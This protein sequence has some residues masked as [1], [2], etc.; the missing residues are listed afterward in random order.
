M[1]WTDESIRK[2]LSDRRILVVEDDID[3][4]PR[5]ERWLKEW[6]VREVVRRRSVRGKKEGALDLLQHDSAF[7]LICLDVMLPR[8]DI[9]LHVSD[10]LQSEWDSIQAEIL[11]MPQDKRTFRQI[12]RLRSSLDEL[13][14]R[15][16]R[17]IDR[18]AGA[19]MVADWLESLPKAKTRHQRHHLSP[20]PILFLTARQEDAV[21][22]IVGAE[23]DNSQW[24]TKPVRQRSLVEAAAELIFS[25]RKVNRTTKPR[26]KK[27]R[28]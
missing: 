19:R 7:D 22:K 10:Q 25:G 14:K 27:G 20:V 11:K 15:M 18:E 5:W 8:D 2:Q 17:L 4:A 9:D 16:H 24:I 3:L 13:A 6:G 26:S 28:K 1:E 21:A 12:A 23:P